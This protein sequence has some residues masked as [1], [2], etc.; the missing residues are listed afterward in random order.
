MNDLP[1]HEV[2]AI[3]QKLLGEVESSSAELLPL[4]LMAASFHWDGMAELECPT[5]VEKVTEGFR[6]YWAPF[7]DQVSDLVKGDADEEDFILLID[8]L[9]FTNSE[10]ITAELILWGWG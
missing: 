4:S 10:L 8:C 5:G 9:D 6:E 7:E 2:S 3:G 1:M